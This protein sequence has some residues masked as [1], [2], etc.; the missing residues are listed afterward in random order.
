M[1]PVEEARGRIGSRCSSTFA[2][3]CTADERDLAASLLQG[4]AGS[5]RKLKRPHEERTVVRVGVRVVRAT[6]LM[7][8]DE[9]DGVSDPYVVVRWVEREHRTRTVTFDLN[10]LRPATSTFSYHELRRDLQKSLWRC[11][12]MATTCSARTTTRLR[13]RRSRS[14][15]RSS[16]PASPRSRAPSMFLSTQVRDPRGGGAIEA[17]AE[18]HE[19]TEAFYE[20]LVRPLLMSARAF[21]LLPSCAV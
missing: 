4:E 13:K 21:L 19:A 6:G 18:A 10:G 3:S 12:C 1:S 14:S 9:P 17:A 16:T 5:C 11:W 15:R 7:N 8:A 20:E 2:D